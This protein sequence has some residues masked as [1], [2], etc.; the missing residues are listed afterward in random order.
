MH[1]D[2]IMVVSKVSNVVNEAVWETAFWNAHEGRR[3]V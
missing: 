3:L 1:M 2:V